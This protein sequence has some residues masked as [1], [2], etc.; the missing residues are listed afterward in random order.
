MS[1]ARCDFGDRLV[2]LQTLINDL[3]ARQVE[4]EAALRK[5][6]VYSNAI[7]AKATTTTK[8]KTTAAAEYRIGG[9]VYTK[10]ATDN[11]FDLAALTALTATKYQCNKLL[12]DAAGAATVVQGTEAASAAAALLAAGATTADTCCV[13]YHTIG[14]GVN[15]HDYS[16][17]EVDAHGGAFVEG[18]PDWAYTDIT[19]EAATALSTYD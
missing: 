15:A 19:A 18:D 11:L 10:A 9:V 17:D 1:L 3:R 2:E 8:I 16:S 5:D 14:D 13:G 6:Q 4:L 12:L 7:L